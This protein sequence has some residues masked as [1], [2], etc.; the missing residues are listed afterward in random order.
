MTTGAR[1]V[2]GWFADLADRGFQK[3]GLVW[4]RRGDETLFS[5]ELQKSQYGSR[6]YVNVGV[7]FLSLGSAEHVPPHRCHFYGRFGSWSASEALDFESRF[8]REREEVVREFKTRELLPAADGCGT[9]GGAAAFFRS[10][11][12]SVPL[13]L[14][15]ARPLL[16]LDD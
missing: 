4:C 8:P 10:G 6:Y 1:A 12:L 9:A 2:A 13:V 11:L 5:F 3:K 16:G 7:F 14:P 15:E